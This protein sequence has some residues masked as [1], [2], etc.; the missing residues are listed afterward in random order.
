[1]IGACNGG[2]GADCRILE[3]L[4][5]HENALAAPRGRCMMPALLPLS[6]CGPLAE[7]A[8]C[9]C[10]LG[11][12]GLV[13]AAVGWCAGAAMSGGIC[14]LASDVE[15]G[16]AGRSGLLGLMAA[17]II[18]AS[19]VWRCGFVGG[20][21]AGIFGERC[22]LARACAVLGAGLILLA[23]RGIDPHRRSRL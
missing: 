10:G 17:S 4:R 14:G 16:F 12:G 22:W 19:L 23:P 21:A 3:V 11:V 5:D 13:R 20:A 8:G 9:F 15:A 1:M 18:A 6:A 2:S 7:I